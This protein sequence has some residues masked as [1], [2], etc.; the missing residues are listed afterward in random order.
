MA[1]DGGTAANWTGGQ[2]GQIPS[3]V[4]DVINFVG[5]ANSPCVLTAAQTTLGGINVQGVQP[6]QGGQPAQQGFTSTITTGG[7]TTFASSNIQGA[8]TINIGVGC[9]FGSGSIG[10]NGG[11]NNARVTINGTEIDVSQNEILDMANVTLSVAT[12]NVDAATVG[13]AGPNAPGML[14]FGYI[15]T[16]NAQPNPSFNIYGMVNT[17]PGQVTFVS[18]SFQGVYADPLTVRN[19][20]TLNLNSNCTIVSYIL[21]RPGGTVDAVGTPQTPNININI[22]GAENNQTNAAL[23]VSGVLNLG[24]GTT[25]TPGSGNV[26]VQAGGGINIAAGAPGSSSAAQINANL[27]LQGTGVNTPA[28]LNLNNG[29]LTIGAGGHAIMSFAA[30]TTNIFFQPN[31]GAPVVGT[32]TVA[33]FVTIN[34]VSTFTVGVTNPQN[35]VAFTK[36]LVTSQGLPNGDFL[37]VLPAIPGHQYTETSLNGVDTLTGT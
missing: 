13:D 6:A 3:T 18:S 27:Y 22:T 11:V 33:S 23:D 30:V 1:T 34:N 26:L 24:V 19:G 36:P 7:G 21:C 16:S 9:D 2:A 28:K 12:V 29:N 20:G 37:F 17:D 8:C 10:V 31:G 32:M 15:D 5:T 14:S 35:A 4:N 25:I